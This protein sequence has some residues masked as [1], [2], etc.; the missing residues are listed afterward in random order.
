MKSLLKLLQALFL[1]CLLATAGCQTNESIANNL[2]EREANEIVVFLASKGIEAQKV[3]AETSET[4]AAGATSVLFKIT[5][6]ADRST[7]A[8][9]LLNR[10]GLPRR[11]GTTLLELFAKTGLMSSDREDTIR[12]QA[13]L[14]EQLTNTIRK[15]D[16]V[17]D[18]VVQIAF[19]PAEAIPGAPASKTTAAV[20]VKH[21]GALEDPNSHIETKIR[22]LLAGSVN[23]LEFEDVS[24]ISDR[25]RLANIT[26]E[27]QQDMISGKNLHQTYVS[28]WSMVMTKGSLLRFRLIFFTLIGLVLLLSAAVGWLAYKFYPHWIQ[29]GDKKQ[30][31]TA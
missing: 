12:Y 10:F 11:K 4:A 23:G 14:A 24:V 16:G 1:L 21:Q 25:S 7:E 3:Q 15:I 13:G 17:L 5:V 22:R 27:P 18:A 8:M 31:P 6:D 9:S 26:L 30:P 29:Q 20:Y 19:P 28:M 2:E